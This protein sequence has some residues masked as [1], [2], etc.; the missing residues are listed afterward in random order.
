[1]LFR[2]LFNYLT[3]LSKVAEYRRLLVAPTRLRDALRERILAACAEA[4]RGGAPYIAAKVNALVDVEMIDLLDDAATR[5]VRIDLIVRGMCGLLPDPTR[6]GDR[7]R[8]RSIIGEFL[9]H[10]RLY[11][12]EIDGRSEWFAG[13]ADLMDR[14]LDRRVEVLF[15]L[16]DPASIERCSEALRVMLDDVRNSWIL[17]PDGAWI[18]REALE[19]E[20]A[21]RTPRSAFDE[22]KRLARSAAQ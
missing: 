6:H 17:Q 19:P 10:S 4:D 22:F 9:E 15:P 16:L 14:N 8:I 3:G 7:L 5:G 12:F 21:G 2:S 13:S 20:L 1:M 11:H 18:R